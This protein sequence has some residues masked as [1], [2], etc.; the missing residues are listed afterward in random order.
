VMP[1]V[2]NIATLLKRWLLGTHQGGVQHVH[3]DYYLTSSPS[4]LIAAV[5]KQEACSSTGSLTRPSLSDRPRTTPSSAT[6]RA[7]CL[8]GS[9][10][11]T[12]GGSR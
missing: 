7:K 2:H 1:R 6:K 3:L 5:Q 10:S 11:S 4:G 8:G 9:L 12:E